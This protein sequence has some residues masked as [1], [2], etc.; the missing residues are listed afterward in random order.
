M[1]LCSRHF[2]RRFWSKFLRKRHRP[3]CYPNPILAK[4]SERTTLVDGLLESP[5]MVDLLFTL[6]ERYYGSGVMRRN[7][8]SSA[9]F[10]RLDLF[11][12]NFYLDRIVFQEPFWH[13]KTR[14]CATRWWRPHPSAFPRFDTI[15]E[16][17]EQIDKQTDERIWRSLWRALKNAGKVRKI[18]H[19]VEGKCQMCS[20]LFDLQNNKTM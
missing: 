14:D 6:I 8:Y 1:K 15:S 5:C 19:K 18:T 13:Q 2:S 20:H 12:L 4:V 16:C 7:E 9:V 3:I 10:A 11:A 17:D